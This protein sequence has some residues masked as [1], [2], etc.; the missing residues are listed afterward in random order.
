MGASREIFATRLAKLVAEFDSKPLV[1]WAV[2][3]GVTSRATAIFTDSV[4]Y[5]C[6]ILRYM[7]SN[8]HFFVKKKRPTWGLK[9]FRHFH[10]SLD[11]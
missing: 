1:R 9:I 6:E 2:D 11:P 7:V 10:T 8:H 4:M 5:Y 3:A